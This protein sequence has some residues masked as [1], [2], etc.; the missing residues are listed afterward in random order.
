MFVARF[1][2]LVPG[3]NDV[4]AAIVVL[5]FII[6]IIVRLLDASRADVQAES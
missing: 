6:I 1:G 3:R 5:A 2:H 4:I